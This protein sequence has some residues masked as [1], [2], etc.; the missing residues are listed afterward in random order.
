MHDI[1]LKLYVKIQSLASDE[2][3]QD[4]IEYALAA[5]LVALAVV[6]SMKHLASAVSLLFSTIASTL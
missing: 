6:T 3:G 5:S 2:E 4:L 1:L